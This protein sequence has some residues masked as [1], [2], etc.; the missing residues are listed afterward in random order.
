MKFR[1]RREAK[2]N[3]ER[4]LAL[5]KSTIHRIVVRSTNKRIIGQI[6]SYSEKGD[7][8]KKYVD[9]KKLDSYGWPSRA[10]RA[11]A[12]L[13]GMLLAKETKGANDDYILDIGLRASTKGSIPF[14]FAKGCV[15]NGMKLRGTFD[16]E[17]SIYNCTSTSK[18]ASELKD[19]KNQFSKYEKGNIKAESLTALFNKVRDEL[20]K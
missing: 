20:K 8:V 7:V 18:Y 10:N 19:K 14:I 3:Y 11:T 16:I 9:S 6:V 13:T 5:V 12:Y 15:D 4:R 1:R 2:T 17:E